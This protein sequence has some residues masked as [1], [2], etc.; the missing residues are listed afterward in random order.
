M[1][2]EV[3]PS[4]L[5]GYG[6]RTSLPRQSPGCEGPSC[7]CPRA[8]SLENSNARSQVDQAAKGGAVQVELG[9]GRHRELLPDPRDIGGEPQRTGGLA[10]EGWTRPL[11]PSH[12]SFT[13]MNDAPESSE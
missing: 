4:G 7:P 10:T 8:V 9:W 1:V 13:D 3:K 2:T 5:L 6:S 11:Q 12:R